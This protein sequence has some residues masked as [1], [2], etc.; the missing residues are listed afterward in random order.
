MFFVGHVLPLK[1]PPIV[2]LLVT[3]ALAF[4]AMN[5]GNSAINVF[6][7]HTKVSKI[8][9]ATMSE[10]HTSLFYCDFSYIYFLAYIVPYILD[11][12]I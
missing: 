1:I 9:G 4:A 12:V 6:L 11:A 3:Y 8:I 10:P 2:L 5:L 7:P